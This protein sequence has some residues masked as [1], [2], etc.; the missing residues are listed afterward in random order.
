ML[1]RL[2]DVI[3]YLVTSTNPFCLG[4]CVEGDG[5]LTGAIRLDDA[6]E[7]HL[8]VK[9]HLKLKNLDEAEYNNFFTREW[10]HGVKRIF[11]GANDPPHFALSPPLDAM[12]RREKMSHIVSRS[13]EKKDYIITR[14]VGVGRGTFLLCKVKLM[15]LTTQRG[16]DNLLQP[17]TDRHPFPGGCPG[18]RCGNC[19]EQGTKGTMTQMSCIWL[20]TYLPTHVFH[21][22]HVC[23]LEDSP[24]RRPGIVTVHPRRATEAVSEKDSSSQPPV[25]SSPCVHLASPN[26]RCHTRY[27]ANITCRWSAVARG[28]VIRVLQDKLAPLSDLSEP[29]RVMVSQIPDVRLRKSRYSYGHSALFPIEEL[30]DFDR[31]LDKVEKNGADG[32]DRTLRVNWYL[33]KVCTTYVPFR[34]IRMSL[35]QIPFIGA[36]SGR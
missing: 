4:E 10:E 6:F 8:K 11:N 27:C 14:F 7:D 19:D 3:S 2:Q 30:L 31:R 12:R 22:T 24:R 32:K 23:A 25:C 34:S 5:S 9:T 28:A 29:Q 13:K 18:Q 16:D 20:P 15:T 33:K 1:T 21:L 36:S 35:I 26:L 17:V